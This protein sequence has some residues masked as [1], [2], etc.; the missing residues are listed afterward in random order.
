M[1][2]MSK[3]R[4][5]IILA[6]TALVVLAYWGTATYFAPPRL[7][8]EASGTIETT[9]VDV[10]FQVAGKVE[11]LLV[12]EGD[13]VGL[14]QV[15]AR[16]EQKPLEENLERVRGQLSAAD[17]SAKQQRAALALTRRTIEEQEKA[18]RA[19]MEAAAAHSK[20][21]HTGPRLQEMRR[22]EAALEAAE[23]SL[24]KAEMD[25]NRARE[26]VRKQVYSQSAL[27]AALAELSN[28][29]SQRDRAREDLKLLR[30]GSRRE[31]IEAA[32]AQLRQAQALLAQASAN[33]LQ[34]EIK[35]KDLATALA[36]LQELQAALNLAQINLDYGALKAPIAG[37]ILLKNIE[38][39]EVVNVGTPVFTMGDIEDVW[40]NVY[41][42]TEA[43]GRLRLGDPVEVK[44]DAYRDQGFPG[45]IVFISQEAEFTPKNIQTRDERTKLVYR[46]KVSI[47][48]KEQ[49]LKPGMP[50]DAV[51]R[52]R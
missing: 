26:L 48:N 51:L 50:A 52:L 19:G 9:E 42:G 1:L 30:E 35:E 5:G 41:V 24:T 22:G 27:D 17:A 47:R 28:A 18:A 49:K 12:D 8:L 25:A 37:W 43:V 32:E 4:I 38:A 23:A 14:G 11:Q 10:S 45:K 7:D 3:K 40:M 34:V 31:E 13:H 39:G 2:R 6:V 29:Q 33:R 36:H 20:E 21:V 46:V 15:V 16:L 44:V